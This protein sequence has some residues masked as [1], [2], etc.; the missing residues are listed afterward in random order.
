MKSIGVLAAGFLACSL[1]EAAFAGCQP[2]N[3]INN[4]AFPIDISGWTTTSGTPSHD[5]S[6]GSSL[7]GSLQVVGAGVDISFQQCVDMTGFALPIP[8][9]F[10]IDYRDASAN[11]IETLTVSV[12]DYTDP[13]CTP[14]NETGNSS[15]AS[16]GITSTSYEQVSGTHTIGVAAQGVLFRVQATR[17]ASTITGHFDDAFLGANVVYAGCQPGNYISNCGFPS[18]I[19]GW[20]TTSG[21]PSHDPTEGSSTP[22]SLQVV[23]AGVDISFQQCVNVTGL[24]LPMGISYGID[25]RDASANAME[26]VRVSVS[27]Y[28]DAACTPGNETGN[29]SEATDGITSTS[30]EQVSGAHTIGVSAQGVLFRVYAQRFSS[31]IT[32]HFDDAF[33]GANVVPVDLQSIAIE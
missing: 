25:Y 22:G 6:E 12:S 32:G 14:G 4:C 18:N 30:Y 2:G 29:S 5:P 9:N 20:T 17:F 7:P 11:A 8:V 16:D 31:T 28:T 27:D 15:N 10:G 13:A 26:T 19:L 1:T 21:S 23:G 3:F 24:A 33:V